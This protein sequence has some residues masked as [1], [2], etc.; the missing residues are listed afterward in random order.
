M[1]LN[2]GHM[3]VNEVLRSYVKLVCELIFLK[4]IQILTDVC[5]A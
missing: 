1:T 4:F 5:P 3:D 2:T